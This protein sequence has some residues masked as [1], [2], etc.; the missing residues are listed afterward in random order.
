MKQQMYKEGVYG[1]ACAAV[2]AAQRWLTDVKM[3]EMHRGLKN[4][5]NIM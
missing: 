5:M 1:F 2:I 3:Y 4:E